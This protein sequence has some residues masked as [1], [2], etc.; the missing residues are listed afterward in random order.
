[1][2]AQW[3]CDC[4]SSFQGKHC[5]ELKLSGRLKLDACREGPSLPLLLSSGTAD[6]AFGTSGDVKFWS[7]QGAGPAVLL[8]GLREDG[9]FGTTGP[10]LDL[11]LLFRFGVLASACKARF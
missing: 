8:L 5:H 2:T 4:Q 1:M 3:A 9:L 7:L 11:L 6:A 10:V